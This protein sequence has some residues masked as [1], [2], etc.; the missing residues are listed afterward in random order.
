LPWGCVIIDYF[1][2]VAQNHETKEEKREKNAQELDTLF[3][4]GG[5][6]YWEA[7]DIWHTIFTNHNPP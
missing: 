4:N 1:A 2:N 5:E 6:R 7:S 3:Y